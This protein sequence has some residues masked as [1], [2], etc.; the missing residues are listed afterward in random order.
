MTYLIGNMVMSWFSF[1]S[2]NSAPSCIDAQAH[3]HTISQ[4]QLSCNSN[5]DGTLTSVTC[6]VTF[7]IVL[8]TC[9]CRSGRGFYSAHH[10]N[11]ATA[12]CETKN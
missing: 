5:S 9:F 7:V 2:T 12:F 4:L 1:C 8:Q 11:L 10:I 3:Y 6:V